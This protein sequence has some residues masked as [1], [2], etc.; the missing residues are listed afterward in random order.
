MPLSA[1]EAR[2]R[3]NEQV[4]VEMLVKAAKNCQRC[5]LM[6]L[7]SEEDHHDP[8]N[9]A[10]AITDTGKGKY[11]EVK[12]DDPAGHFKGKAIRVT[13][14][15]T[16]KGD[17]PQIE[18]DNPGQIE[19]VTDTGTR[20]DIAAEFV[21]AIVNAFEANKRLADRAVE[22]V[23]D[24]KLHAALDANT[25]SIAV[26]MKHV[27]G[28]LASR[29][30]DFL[31]ADGEKPWRNRDDEFVDSFGSRADLLEL[32]ERG[33]AC[34]LTTLKGLKREDLEK[35][36]LIRGE[37]HSVPLAL[38]RSLGHTCYHIGQIVQVARIHAGEQWATLTI[39]RGGSEEFNKANWGQTG[40]SHS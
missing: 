2:T 18:V 11:R 17:Q 10:V 12:I 5:S 37:P 30:T 3:I 28:N 8:K 27:A 7:D 29:W 36:V 19:V 25:N 34:L 21:S 23:P 13:G 6:F 32:W 39:P 4:T 14:L 33:W 35:T 9:F 20:M 31:T 15:V 16:L 22:Q 38:E 26:L 40:K 1:P 24:D